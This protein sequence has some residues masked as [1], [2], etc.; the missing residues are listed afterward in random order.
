MGLVFDQQETYKTPVPAAITFKR[1]SEVKQ[2]TS[3]NRAFLQSLGL[4]CYR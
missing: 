2:L 4:T 1:R 3:R